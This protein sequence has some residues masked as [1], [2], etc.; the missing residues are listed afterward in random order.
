MSQQDERH[1]DIIENCN[2]LLDKLKGCPQTDSTPEGRMISQLKWLK[3]RAVTGALPLPADRKY[4]STLRHVF[5][6]GML[7]RQA[8]T[9]DEYVRTIKV[10]E[11]RLMSLAKDGAFLLKKEYYP[12]A[13]R[14]IGKLINVMKTANRPLSANEQAAVRELEELKTKLGQIQIEPPLM[15]KEGYPHFR[16]MY[17]MVKCSIDDLEDGKKLCRLVTDLVFNGI[18]P[19]TWQTP[20]TADRETADWRGVV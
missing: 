6:E 15:T 2:I 12:Y 8:P 20:E 7:R 14:C 10:Y 4:V 3:E 13:V 19:S 9:Q 16:K 11:Y 5:T 18:R 17:P 1:Q